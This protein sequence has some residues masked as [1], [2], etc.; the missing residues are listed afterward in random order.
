VTGGTLN[1][2]VVNATSIG[3]TTP[4]TGAFTTLTASGAAT[5]TDA[6]GI[7][8]LQAA[9]QDAV[10]LVGRAGGSSSHVATITPPTL[11]GN[12][13]ITLPAATSALATLALTETFTNKT[14]TSPAISGGTINNASVG[15]TT[16]STG[17]FTTL[18]ASGAVTFSSTLNVAASST[19]VGITCGSIT[20][21]NQAGLTIG[22]VGTSTTNR[23]WRVGNTGGGFF[24][25]VESSGGGSLF[26]GT[27][28][29]AT[30]FGT[31]TN[32]SLAFATNNA[33]RVTLS[34]TALTFTDSIN[35]VF[36]TGTG[37]KI[38]TATGQKI[39]L[40][41]ATPVIQP[42]AV[43]DATGGGT[44]DTEARA[45]INALLSRMRTVG[46]VAT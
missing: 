15:A 36:N 25:G 13:T 16:T 28:G 30:A 24:L 39:G 10:A 43:A 14:L 4:G 1:G 37:T 2:V 45:A 23:Y 34:N 6:S 9:T 35:I 8:S 41:N 19:F 22:N 40:W 17:G 18:A 5:V 44:I 3:A 29:Y 26:T 21:S 12:A 33:T 46:M 32:T 11:A 7:T 42:T 31:I 38:G 27:A 20:Q